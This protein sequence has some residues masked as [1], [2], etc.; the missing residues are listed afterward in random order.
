MELWYDDISF[1]NPADIESMSVLKDAS[2]TAIY[3]LRVANGAIVITTKKGGKGNHHSQ[4]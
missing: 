3:G 2:S 1:L 4:L